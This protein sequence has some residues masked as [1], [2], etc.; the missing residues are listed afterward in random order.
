MVVKIKNPESS[1]NDDIREA[2][3]VLE[4]KY[5]QTGVPQPLAKMDANIKLLQLFQE[6]M[7][8]YEDL[9]CLL[10]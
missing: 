1:M 6:E 8:C 5:E 3:D 9:F 2:R 10:P 4:M 7:E